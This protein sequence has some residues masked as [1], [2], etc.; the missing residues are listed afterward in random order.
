MRESLLRYSWGQGHPDALTLTLMSGCPWRQNSRV[1][2]LASGCPA[3]K[4]NSS[5]AGLLV[6]FNH[7]KGLGPCK[8]KIAQAEW[9]CLAG[10]IRRLLALIYTIKWKV[11]N[12]VGWQIV[13]SSQSV[14][15][16]VDMCNKFFGVLTL[17]EVIQIQLNEYRF[18]AAPVS[19]FYVSVLESRCYRVKLCF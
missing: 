15:E 7:K 11:I 17:I 8:H 2:S 16:F 12:W 1:K 6:N 3:S 9:K 13:S 4:G 5:S 10:R 19:D 18:A 14:R